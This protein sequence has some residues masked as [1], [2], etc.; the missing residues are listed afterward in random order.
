MICLQIFWL[1]ISSREDDGSPW[2]SNSFILNHVN[3]AEIAKS[4]YNYNILYI[5]IYYGYLHIIYEADA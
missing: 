5:I 4:K 3:I 2:K 1:V